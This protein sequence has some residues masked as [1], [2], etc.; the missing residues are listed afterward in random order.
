MT[1]MIAVKIGTAAT[2]LALIWSCSGRRA[3]MI[4]MAVN[5]AVALVQGSSTVAQDTAEHLA[6]QQAIDGAS[7]AMGETVEGIDTSPSALLRSGFLAAVNRQDWPGAAVLWA[8]WDDAPTDD[9]DIV[10][11]YNAMLSGNGQHAEAQQAAWTAAVAHESD[12]DRFMEQWYA[13][14]AA[15][16][17]YMRNEVRTIVPGEDAERIEHMDRGTSLN[18]VFRNDGDRTH[19]FK[20]MQSLHLTSYRGEM[21]AWRLCPLMHCVISLPHTEEVRISEADFLELTGLSSVSEIPTTFVREHSE[22][23]WHEDE[24]GERWLY[25][26]IKAWVPGFTLY[27]I[28]SSEVWMPLVRSGRT[29]S[30]LSSIRF[31]DAVAGVAL[32]DPERFPVILDRGRG[33]DGFE[34]AHQVSDLHVFDLLINNW[35]RYRPNS[36]GANCQWDHGQFVSIDNGATFQRNSEEHTFRA[37]QY[38]IDPVKVFSRST[39]DALRWMQPEAVAGLL[40]ADGPWSEG[41]DERV[42]YFLER[43]DWLLNYVDELIDSHGEDAVLIFP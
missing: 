38:H 37:Q 2:L 25:G 41:D 7:V 10:F 29:E 20:P 17:D 24:A 39:I 4:Q 42:A 5:E 30:S 12:R 26:V 3:E 27:P 11:A 43:R 6:I 13:S 16:P 22:L 31:A 35:D 32:I 23:I 21:A 14:F 15:D 18:F 28:E 19:A 33:V 40:F 8:S 9:V 1:R 34:F 36:P